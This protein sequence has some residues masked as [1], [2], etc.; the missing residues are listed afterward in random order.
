MGEN[1]EPVGVTA[2][3]WNICGEFAACPKVT[4][5]VGKVAQVRTL[6]QSRGAEVVLLQEICEWQANRL[7]LD[8]RSGD[9]SWN[10][11][12]APLRQIDTAGGY[13]GRRVRGCDLTRYAAKNGKPALTTTGHA[14]GQA[15]LVQ[16]RLDQ[17]TSYEL[18]APTVDLRPAAA[19]WPVGGEERSRLHHALHA[20]RQ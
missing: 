11:A 17:I 3:N 15:V 16:G 9:S 7:L 14:Y 12:F 18:A 4:D 2:L 6:A 10:L 8:L 1:G 20:V 19:L 5:P 13:P